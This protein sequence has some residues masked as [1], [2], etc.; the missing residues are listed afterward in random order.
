MEQILP[1]K[2]TTVNDWVVKRS[3]NYLI[4]TKNYVS[5]KYLLSNNM[6]I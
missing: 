6:S 3:T 2:T 1:G 4:A 5:F